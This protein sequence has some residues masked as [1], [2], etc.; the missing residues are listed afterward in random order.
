MT[1][2]YARKSVD[3]QRSLGLPLASLL[4]EL[5]RGARKYRGGALSIVPFLKEAAGVCRGRGSLHGIRIEQAGE[6][7][8]ARIVPFR[9]CAEP[10]AGCQPK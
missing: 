10:L 3:R 4:A 8:H 9:A 5:C 7:S 1:I 6:D 2:N